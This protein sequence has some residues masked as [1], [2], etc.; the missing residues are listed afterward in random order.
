MNNLTKS[1]LIKCS[2]TFS[3]GTNHFT[4]P[5]VLITVTKF[6]PT[7]FL[8]AMRD[9]AE[10]SVHMFDS[11]HENPELMWKDETRDMV[12]MTVRNMTQE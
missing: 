2:Y 4:N 8:D 12:Q 11:E 1:W 9:S 5:Q 7:I 6:L 10:N 3:I